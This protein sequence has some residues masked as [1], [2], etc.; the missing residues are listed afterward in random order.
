MYCYEL[1]VCTMCEG[2]VNFSEQGI[3]DRDAVFSP[4]EL[5]RLA[6]TVYL[7]IGGH[8]IS[9]KR[10]GRLGESMLLFSNGKTNGIAFYERI[11]PKGE[12]TFKLKPDQ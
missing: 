8:R 12:V 5:S 9:W 4:S 11:I 3:N 2:C 10:T 1:A 7:I 6:S